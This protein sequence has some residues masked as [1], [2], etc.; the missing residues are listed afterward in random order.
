MSI[1]TDVRV[2]NLEAQV[3][4]IESDLKAALKSLEHIADMVAA[5]SLEQDVP[6]VN[7]KVPRKLNG[8]KTQ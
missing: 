7:T 3:A 4:R 1:K 5:D 8:T 6:K 2:K